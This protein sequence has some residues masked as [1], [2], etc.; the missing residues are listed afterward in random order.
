[1]ALMDMENK[2]ITKSMLDHSDNFIS[3]GTKRFLK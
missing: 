1:M 2:P 3:K